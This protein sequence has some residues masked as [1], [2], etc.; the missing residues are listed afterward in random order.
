M[1]IINRAALKAQFRSGTVP[2]GQQYADLIDSM[3]VK[4]D[5]A[6]FGKWKPGIIYRPGDVVIYEK[7][8]YCCVT[9]ETDPCGCDD[10]GDANK[11]KTVEPSSKGFCSVYPPGKKGASEQDYDT[12][13]WELL[14]IDIED[15]D[16]GIIRSNDEGQDI[17]YAKVFGKIGM[18]TQEPHARVQIHDELLKADF[19]FSPGQA[20]GPEF[21]INNTEQASENLSIRL[22]ENKAQFTTGTD[23]FLFQIPAHIAEAEKNQDQAQPVSDTSSQVFITSVNSKPAVGA[24]TL[25][26]LAAIDLKDGL[27]RNLLLNPWNRQVPEIFW[28]HRSGSTQVCLSVLTN[29]NSAQFTTN[30]KGGFNFQAG[31]G[32]DCDNY[33]KD[34]NNNE[35]RVLLSIRQ[36]VRRGDTTKRGLLGIGTNEPTDVLDIRDPESNTGKF[37]MSFRR[38]NPA[39]A[40]INVRP[41]G[42]ASNY[43]TMG[44]DNE[45]AIFITDAEDGFVFKKG[46]GYGNENEIDIDQGGEN[47]LLKITSDAK[48]GIGHKSD[49]RD[50]EL[51]VFGNSRMF[52]LYISTGKDKIKENGEIKGMLAKLKDLRPVRF[53]WRG[54]Y[55]FDKKGQYGFFAH[56]V[57]DVLPELI[58]E[59]NDSK[60]IAFPGLVAVLVKAVQEQQ[61]IIDK[62]KKISSDLE[63]RIEALESKGK[64]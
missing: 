42:E 22:A 28:S 32:E 17:M 13:N 20:D 48:V 46:E 61:E 24:G 38:T 37:L 35:G 33:I 19:L 30:A 1:A 29:E 64:K 41:G 7:A 40:I 50:Y 2:T 34:G 55:D 11:Q 59:S 18:G 49:P 43:V 16:W 54:D 27:S 62:M 15:D 36:E 39:L 6:F 47:S 57:E 12:Q 25:T 51:D 52:N 26:P 53:T 9:Q 58:K 8:I 44:A 5:D 31:I 3:L 4:R 56:E 60:S 63:K 21:Q 14:D 45:K 23:G 10:K